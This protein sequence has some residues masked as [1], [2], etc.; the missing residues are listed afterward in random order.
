MSGALGQVWDYL[1]VELWEP[2]AGYS[3]ENQAAPQDLFSDL[4]VA[5]DEFLSPRPTANE[6]EEVRNDFDNARRRFLALKGTDFTNESAIV[7]F[8]EAARDVIA[9]YE[10]PGYEDFYQ[11]QLRDVL[12]K[13]NLRYRL[14]E[15]FT[16]RFLIPGSFAN[17]YAELQRLNSG[18]HHLTA[19]LS[20]FEKAFDRFA[21][22]QDPADLKHC[23]HMASNYA[24]ALASSTQGRPGTLGAL[25]DQLK[26]WP[27]GK[28]KEAL[29]DVY[30]FC[31][32]Y[33]GIRHGGDPANVL[34]DLAM[35]D[36][37]LTSFLL[38]SFAGYLSSKL[39]ERAVLG[40]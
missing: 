29:K 31:S 13:F 4:F 18:N 11:R 37:T 2:L 20:D 17:L 8:L 10:I 5:A 36:A 23:I 1:T 9:N 22:I 38:L 35:R 3:S 40:I 7:N 25:C 6:L 30:K 14:D 26:D 32:D 21:R 33:P 19:R 28:L 27:H 12:R 34:R 16:L 39:D 24:E 15:P